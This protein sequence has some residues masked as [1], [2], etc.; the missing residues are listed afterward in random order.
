[1]NTNWNGNS[2]VILEEFKYLVEI[3][4]TCFLLPFLNYGYQKILSGICGSHYVSIRKCWSKFK[5]RKFLP[6][7]K[8]Q[9]TTCF[10]YRP[11]VKNGF[12]FLNSWKIWR[13]KLLFYSVKTVWNSNFINRILLENSHALLFIYC[14]RLL[15]YYNSTRDPI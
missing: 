3:N 14:I 9:S 2:L 4:F 7:G 1:M 13:E 5:P 10:L 11:R 8:I 6:I 12:S 15:S